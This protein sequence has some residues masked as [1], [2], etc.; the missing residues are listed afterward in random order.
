MLVRV[1]IAVK[2]QHDQDNS[3]KG[4]QLGLAYS[5]RGS[6]HYHPGGKHGGMQL[7][8]VL[9]KELRGLYLD[10]QAAEGDCVSHWV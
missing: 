8:M 5:F 4:K 3:Y 10:L 1:S 7:D 6:V 9:E 2:R